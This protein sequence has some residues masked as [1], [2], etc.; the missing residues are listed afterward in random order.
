MEE[1]VTISALNN[2]KCCQ[3]QNK[4]KKR[5]DKRAVKLL[6]F[7]LYY[8][9]FYEFYFKIKTIIIKLIRKRFR[10]IS[11]ICINI[12]KKNFIVFSV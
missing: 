6:F 12:K 5:P 9:G 8:I 4:Q 3:L 2:P 10:Q 1:S 7:P 11:N